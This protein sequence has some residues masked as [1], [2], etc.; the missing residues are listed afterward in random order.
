MA[1]P[2]RWQD[3]SVGSWNQPPRLGRQMSDGVGEKLFQDLYPFMLGEH[4]LTSQ[5]KG[6]SQSLPRVLSPESLSCVE[7]PI[8]LSDGHLPGVPK[9]P[10]QP[11]NCASNLESTRNPEKAG[12]SAP[13]P[14]PRFGRPLKPPSY[15]SQPHSRAGAEN[16]SYADSRQPDPGAAHLARTNS[17]RQDLYGPD[18]GLEPPVYVPPPSYKSPPQPAAHPCPEEAVPR[19]DGGGR[20][21][22]QHLMEK[23]AAGGQPLS[24][25]RGAGSEWGASPCSPVGV[26][27]Q[28]HPTTAYDGSILIIPFNDPRILN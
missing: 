23:P 1:G 9:V 15:G 19:P 3:V 12:T 2:A 18:P 20:R 27:P 11:P 16:G 4:G 28:P 6:K 21:V 22:P 14:R 10:L 7:V 5:S 17:A 13:L 8:P 25:S 26:P 24:G